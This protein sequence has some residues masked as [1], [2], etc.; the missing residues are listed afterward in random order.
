MK[1]RLWSVLAALLGA[2]AVLGE[3]GVF[4]LLR[5]TNRLYA[6][7]GP[8][9]VA[10]YAE[11]FRSLFLLVLVSVSAWLALR[12]ARAASPKAVA[13]M[14]GLLGAGLALGAELGMGLFFHPIS[15]EFSVT[16]GTFSRVE[17][18]LPIAETGPCFASDTRGLF[19][20]SLD[21]HRFCPR[22]LPLPLE[23]KRLEAGLR[24]PWLGH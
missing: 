19:R 6:S 21:G 17:F 12:A 22:L 20:W 8:W 7:D 16:A 10:E 18:R 14:L 11:P 23:S 24:C 5:Y 9:L 4:L 2:L 1:R 15:G 13:G 3:V